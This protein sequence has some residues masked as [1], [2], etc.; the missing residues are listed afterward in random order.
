MYNATLILDRIRSISPN[1]EDYL[2]AEHYRGSTENIVEFDDNTLLSYVLPLLL[3]ELSQL[4]IEPTI[5][6][7]EI[8]ES[9]NNIDACCA[10]REYFDELYL[11]ALFQQHDDLKKSILTI[12]QSQDIPVSGFVTE[13]LKFCKDSNVNIGK[14][15]LKRITPIEDDIESTVALVKHI[16][17]IASTTTPLSD[18][19][20][21]STS[22]YFT[23][24]R[25]VVRE[26]IAPIFGRILH[27]FGVFINHQTDFHYDLK[28]LPLDCDFITTFLS[29]YLEMEYISRYAYLSEMRPSHD[30]VPQI[31][32]LTTQIQET[33]SKRDPNQWKYYQIN[34]KDVTDKVILKFILFE[35]MCEYIKRH[36][37]EYPQLVKI[38]YQQTPTNL[39]WLRKHCST[40][41]IRSVELFLYKHL[42]EVA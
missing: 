40:T 39:E 41:F 23:F 16:E 3:N 30:K 14:D 31:A 24:A 8:A 21:E 1:I 26:T 4:G 35:A 33:L 38:F 22:Q 37:Q 29:P 12:F 19:T 7:E 42:T 18:L 25:H 9:I 20:V 6:F 32:K 28:S 34:K 5:S 17:A 13:I 2:D 10:L 27:A 11:R 36:S 15:I